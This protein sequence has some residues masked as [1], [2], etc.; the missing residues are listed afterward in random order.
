MSRVRYDLDNSAEAVERYINS[1]KSSP[2]VTDVL[3]KG[4][5]SPL[6]SK[7][8][9]ATSDWDLEAIVTREDH[10][11]PDPRKLFGIHADIHRSMTPNPKSV[12]FT[13]A[14]K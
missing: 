13:E 7:S 12:S 10:V 1:V 9:R 6:T 14:I 8:P 2:H 3:V 5:R 4:S 11:I